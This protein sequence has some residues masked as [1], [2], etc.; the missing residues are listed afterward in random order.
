MN[1]VFIRKTQAPEA[2]LNSSAV[3]L[4]NVVLAR[5]IPLSER[6]PNRIQ[7]IDIHSIIDV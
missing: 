6:S 4:P 2:S 7:A 5:K 1:S 3:P